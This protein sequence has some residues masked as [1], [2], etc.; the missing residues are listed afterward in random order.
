MWDTT[1]YWHEESAIGDVEKGGFF[2]LCFY[3]HNDT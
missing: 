2:S 3:Q 1:T